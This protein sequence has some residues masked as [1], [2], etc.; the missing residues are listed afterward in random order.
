MKKTIT[1]STDHGHEITNIEVDN[2]SNYRNFEAVNMTADK[3]K[4]KI[5]ITLGVE[6]NEQVLVIG[7]TTLRGLEVAIFKQFITQSLNE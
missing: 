5:G 3:T 2:S 6:D 1:L 7:K 4:E